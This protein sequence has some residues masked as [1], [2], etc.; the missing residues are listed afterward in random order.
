VEDIV[1]CYK[2]LDLAPGASP[3]SVR[4]SYV[5]LSQVWDPAKYIANPILYDRAAKKRREIDDAYTAIKRFLPG[6][7]RESEDA[8]PQAEE[9]RDFQEMVHD[10]PLEISRGMMGIVIGIVFFLLVAWAL[11]LLNRTRILGSANPLPPALAE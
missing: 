2:I 4:R 1:Q 5:E 6:L 8:D 9:R 10:G 7:T 3:E 11:Y